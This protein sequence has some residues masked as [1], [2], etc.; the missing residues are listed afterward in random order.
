MEGLVPFPIEEI[1]VDSLPS[2]PTD[3]GNSVMA[4]AVPKATIADVL[5][6]FP[7]DRMPDR[8]IPDFVSLV[9]LGVRLKPG[10]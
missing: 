6:L 1:L 3:T 4:L 7:Q 2:G 5:M 10:Q 8:V 9:S